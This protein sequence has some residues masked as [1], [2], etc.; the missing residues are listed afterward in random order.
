MPS[1]RWVSLIH[2]IS[3]APANDIYP[4]VHLRALDMLSVDGPFHE[5]VTLVD[6]L[7]VPPR[8]G[9]RLRCYDAHLGFDQQRLW[10]NIEKK[11]GFMGELCS[12]SSS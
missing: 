7:I 1:L 3:S 4:V 8:C 5:S 6:H 10:A 9:L 11:D 12:E 2:A